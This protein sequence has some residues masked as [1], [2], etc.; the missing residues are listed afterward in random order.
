MRR[1]VKIAESRKVLNA[2]IGRSPCTRIGP[3]SWGTGISCIR[4]QL[5]M[6]AISVVMVLLG[7]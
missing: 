1:S 4:V 5:V 3:M 6:G 7:R 2:V